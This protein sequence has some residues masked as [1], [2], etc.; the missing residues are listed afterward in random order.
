MA[1]VRPVNIV[2]V[3]IANDKTA[4]LIPTLFL[5][6]DIE[7]TGPEAVLEEKC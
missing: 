2:I 7:L 3:P 1:K 6:F 5:H 4:Q